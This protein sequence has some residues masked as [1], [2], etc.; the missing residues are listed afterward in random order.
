M[1]KLLTQLWRQVAVLK[2]GGND[3]LRKTIE[4]KPWIA[5]TMLSI[6]FQP[7]KES[8]CEC[9]GNTT[10]HL[11]RFVHRDGS[12]YAVYLAQFVIGHQPKVL[13][14]IIGLGKWGD[15]T[16]AEDRVAFPFRIW[17]VGTR[18]QVGLANAADSP[19]R[20]AK[21]MGKILDREAA[22]KHEWVSEAFRI[23]DQMVAEDQEIISFFSAPVD[24]PPPTDDLSD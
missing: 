6:E 8:R 13:E 12:A 24:T 19:Y 23:T 5:N 4:I 15:G 9:C 3:L 11:S 7:P 20:D 1:R 17:V 2:R 18:F 10:I 21:I 14:G 22:L 16:Q